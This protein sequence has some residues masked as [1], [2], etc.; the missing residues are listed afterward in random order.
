MKLVTFAACA[1]LAAASAVTLAAAPA[2][3]VEPVIAK[4]AQPVATATKFIAGEAV[5]SCAGDTCVAITPQSQT[6]SSST[7]KALAAKFG[8][9]T[10]YSWAKPMDDT[11]MAAC[12][13]VAVAKAAAGPA[14]AKQ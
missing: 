12:N 11:R 1:A 6:F 14:L 5:F 3:A 9:V 13:S 10:S 2:Y 4:L 7:C 8:P